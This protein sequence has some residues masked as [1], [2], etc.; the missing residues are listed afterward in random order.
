MQIKHYTSKKALK[1]VSFLEN[2]Q[3]LL[4]LSLLRFS[5]FFAVKK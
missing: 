2:A 1:T 4:F 3:F 5:A